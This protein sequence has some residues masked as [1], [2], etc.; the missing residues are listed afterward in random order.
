MYRKV[1]HLSLV[2]TRNLSKHLEHLV[3]D[4]WNLRLFIKKAI[5]KIYNTYILAQKYIFLVDGYGLSVYAWGLYLH[6]WMTTNKYTIY[7][8]NIH[9]HWITI[10]INFVTNHHSKLSMH[11]KQQNSLKHSEETRATGHFFMST[12]FPWEIDTG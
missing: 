6:S 10:Q 5:Y 2:N 4:D 1:I 7:Y 9:V 11:V 12:G 8:I 3:H